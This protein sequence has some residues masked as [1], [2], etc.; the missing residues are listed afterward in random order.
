MLRTYFN[1]QIEK[2]LKTKEYLEIFLHSIDYSIINFKDQ[3]ILKFLDYYEEKNSELFDLFNFFDFTLTNKTFFNEKEIE[4]LNILDAYQSIMFREN[5][6][7]ESIVKVFKDRVFFDFIKNLT[8]CNKEETY[9]KKK[10]LL[11]FNCNFL[12]EYDYSKYKKIN[13]DIQRQSND[14]YSNCFNLDYI[15]N[16]VI[17]KDIIKELS[18]NEID[19]YLLKRNGSYTFK[20][21][22]KSFRD[23]KIYSSNEKLR[24]IAHENIESIGTNKLKN[25]KNNHDIAV[26]ILEQ[27]KSISNLFNSKNMLNHSIK[28]NFLDNDTKIKNILDHN[29]QKHY[30]PAVEELQILREFVKDEFDIDNLKVEHLDYYVDQFKSMQSPLS[31]HEVEAYLPI[32]NVIN[33]CFNKIEELFSIKFKETE[34]FDLIDNKEDFLFFE[35]FYKRQS[36]GFLIIDLFA[37]HSKGEDCYMYPIKKGNKNEKSIYFIN[38]S[39]ESRTHCELDF[40]SIFMHE[41]G[42]VIDFVVYDSIYFFDVLHNKF[43][44]DTCEI[45][46][47]T[48]EKYGKDLDFIYQLTENKQGE[49]INKEELEEFLIIRTFFENYDLCYVLACS[50][51]DYTIHSIEQDNLFSTHDKIFSNCLP[52]YNPYNYELIYNFHHTFDSFYSSNY[53]S[54]IFAQSISTI[55]FEKIKEDSK[56]IKHFKYK[57]LYNQNKTSFDERLLLFFDNV[58]PKE[59]KFIEK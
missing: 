51:F 48:M 23:A 11:L 26:N 46:S 12:S 47:T 52:F 39:Q 4:D 43:E 19:R 54:Y 20:Q 15:Y 21:S 45:L 27:E 55:L 17:S 5:E 58:L 29:K 3:N 41:L 59:L 44:K 14:Y 24:V 9:L 1:E 56:N 28:N 37:R 34:P 13:K 50:Y 6:V 7:L 30:E 42:H 32:N 25:K 31:E 8:V 35:L 49:K 33:G 10:F 36:R 57:M 38:M 53:Y 40:V 2:T 18:Q 16:Q 22:L